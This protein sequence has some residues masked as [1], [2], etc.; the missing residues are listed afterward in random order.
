MKSIL[1]FLLFFLIGVVANATDAAP[2]FY[3]QTI[4]VST[5]ND[6]IAKS[7][8]QDLQFFLQKATGRSFKVENFAGQDAEGIYVL[9]NEPSR[10]PSAHRQKF[11]KG[12][13]ED[14]VIS[15]DSRRLHLLSTHPAGFSRSIYTFLDQ[16][17][18][19]WYFPGDEW[20]HVPWLSKITISTQQYITPSFNLRNFFGTGSILPAKTIDPDRTL[21]RSWDDWKR[22]NRMGGDVS[23][24]GH[25][26]ETFN[27]K[28]K[29]LLEANPSW[30]ALVN[31]KRVAWS[32][33][34][35]WCISNKQLR[36]VY[37]KDRVEE[38]QS[39]L[40]QSKYKTEKIVVSVDPADGYNECECSECKK[41][42]SISN[43]YFLMANE[44]AKAI[45][46]MSPQAFV[47]IYAYNTHAEVPTFPTESNMLV[48][49]IPYAFQNGRTPNQLIQDWTKHH[50]YLMLY[51]YYG[52]PDW[53]FDLPLTAAYTPEALADK[54]AFWKSQDIKGFMLESS[55]G[56]GSTGTGL[57]YMSRLGWDINENIS[58]IAGR[59][60]EQLFGTASLQAKN[61]FSKL[62]D[63][64]GAVD[65]P[66]LLNQLSLAKSNEPAVQKRLASLKSYTHYLVLYYQWSNAPENLKEQTLDEL[67]RYNWSSYHLRMVH[68][69]RI[70]E[71]MTRKS[72]DFKNM[73]NRY[74]IFEPLGSV[75]RVL[76]Q[77][78]SRTIEQDFVSDVRNYPL[79]AGM[80]YVKPAGNMKFINKSAAK[81]EANPQGM[82]LVEFPETYVMPSPD[83]SINFML[84]INE[85]SANNSN[86]KVEVTLVDT[87]DG[88]HMAFQTYDIGPTWK[89]ISLKATAGKAYRIYMKSG[90]WFK[91]HFPPAQWAAFKSIPTYSMMGKLY[92]F[93][94]QGATHIYY[95]NN[96]AEQP[97]VSDPDGKAI[98]AEKLKNGNMFRVPV[99]REAAGKWWSV[100]GTEYKTL[101]FYH[102]PALFFTR[103]DYAINQD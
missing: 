92:F 41:I 89:K 98:P 12:T 40:K 75:M 66:Y 44:V 42:G 15:A 26:G 83:G 16:L 51:D 54:I 10:I 91:L 20:M 62:S 2:G 48:Q 81:E 6:E 102:Q 101:Q 18:F 46:P 72:K 96:A 25:Y 90:T 58:G 11:D 60:Y 21:Q 13:I 61:Y 82:T 19:K 87:V 23:P 69:T 28:Y 85:G 68:T 31:G 73:E 94:P 71:L 93:V 52:I 77:V 65:L 8:I 22:R 100:A 39:R 47:N 24:G 55:F 5:T 95:S 53:H 43:R 3:G 74:N 76:K 1:H 67:V 45:K 49:V 36:A 57:Y 103:P 97:L 80:A 35:K 32:P 27:A 4:F 84:K 59:M 33:E 34:A 17:G 7:S 99:R 9:I 14:F 70:G 50:D 30:L 64:R 37:L 78:D 29:T 86:Q 56:I 63:F 38:L 88:K 79:Q